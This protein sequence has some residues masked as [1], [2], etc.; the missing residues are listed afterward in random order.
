MHLIKRVSLVVDPGAQGPAASA[1]RSL[2]TD[3]QLACIDQARE[4]S[5]FVLRRH[6]KNEEMFLDMFEHEYQCMNLGGQPSAAQIE[7][8]PRDWS[9]LL[10]PTSVCDMIF[11]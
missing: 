9:I 10:P 7:N 6:F 8:L 4:Q 11:V 1:V 3:F 5:A 2:V